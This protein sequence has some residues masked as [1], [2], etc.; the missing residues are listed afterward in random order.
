VRRLGSRLVFALTWIDLAWSR[1]SGDDEQII[2]DL[3]SLGFRVAELGNL[4]RASRYFTL[5]KSAASGTRYEAAGTRAACNLGV[6][7]F[8]NK[9]W[10]RLVSELEP[11]LPRIRLLRHRQIVADT[12]RNLGVAYEKLGQPGRAL[13][14]YEESLAVATGSGDGLR[15]ALAMRSLGG[16]SYQEGL[17]NEA[18]KRWAESLAL[19]RRSKDARG[20]AMMDYWLGVVTHRHGDIGE[21]RKLFE[22]SRSI[23]MRLGLVDL[24]TRSEAALVALSNGQEA[25]PPGPNHSDD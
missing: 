3:I 24:A 8:R 11:E 16:L 15:R 14:M 22:E 10:D 4:E 5:A 6:V 23:C 9:A 19:F 12:L 2:E 7:S 20:M 17:W 21:A 25:L 18:H 1:L 13:P